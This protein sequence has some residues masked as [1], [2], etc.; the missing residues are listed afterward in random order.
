MTTSDPQRRKLGTII[1]VRADRFRVEMTDRIDGYTL[2]GFDG[3]HY[4]ARIGTL[5][6][7]PLTNAYVVAE[8]TG[9]QERPGSA[10]PTKADN[11]FHDVMNTSMRE[12]TLSPLGTLPFDTREKFSF[13]VT[14]FPPLYADVLHVENRDL[15]RILN[16]SDQEVAIPDSIS[17]A[18]KMKALTVGTSVVF[19]GYDVKLRIN[20]FFGAH[21][22]ILGNTGSGKSCTIAS[23][24]QE[25]LGKTNPAPTGGSTFIIF[26]TN[27]E[28]RN[29]FTNLPEQIRRK[30]GRIDHSEAPPLTPPQPH[31][32]REE[33]GSFFLPHWLLTLEEWE[34]LVQA[35]DR[36]QRPI[37][38]NALGITSL[39]S[40][41]SS[42]RRDRLND[43]IV[44]SCI[45]SL[46]RDSENATNA[47]TR[48]NNLL[49]HY[50]MKSVSKT[51][52]QEA[53][54][55]T[56]GNF[57][58]KKVDKLRA[59][60]ETRIRPDLNL[61]TYGNEPFQFSELLEA[62]ELAILYEESYGNRRVRD[63]CATLLT[64][65][66]SL[67][68][69]QEFA[70]LRPT[71][72]KLRGRCITP[73]SFVDDLF[74]FHPHPTGVQKQSQLYILDLSTVDDEV[75]EVV[76]S[77]VTRLVFDRL[78]QND[79]RNTFPVNLVLEEAHRYVP[80]QN[81]VAS[82]LDATRIFERVAKEGRKYGLFLML[83]SQ[84]PSELSGTVLSQC[85][86][87]IVH[88]VQNPEDLQ[89]L[90]RMTPFI[91]ESVL[92]RLASLP[93]QI[94]LIFGTSV[95]I[96]TTF[97][98]RTASPLP[99]S[100]DSDVSSH[101]YRNAADIERLSGRGCDQKSDSMGSNPA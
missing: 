11:S 39:L 92:N 87:F 68:A 31:D 13:G 28:Y 36:V 49:N 38:R 25:A 86:N 67:S 22:A 84:Q 35:S 26:D 6:L 8:V 1:E 10:S 72:K 96:P 70:F 45:L 93:K 100:N 97:K 46:L 60:L 21:S 71:P 82:T 19:S 7:I 12:L 91:S 66:K 73:A 37:L 63:N 27:G 33:L 78:R 17:R 50:P 9:L 85:S 79:P 65:V 98:V 44:A 42:K 43:H 74:G 3:Q 77:V 61:P 76:S 59:T 41:G 83:S 75:V 30:Y 81:V 48:I 5:V 16:V 18:T 62:L 64:R 57:N 23:L 52:I 56:Y 34:L 54:G 24:L 101:W 15:D 29:A 95:S 89:H 32:A 4:I 80:S 20:E 55:V 53:L 40:S 94:A 69:R 51:E 88:R 2:V 47:N 99:H 58:N 14:E 90:R